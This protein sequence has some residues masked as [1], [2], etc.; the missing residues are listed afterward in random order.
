MMH[1]PLLTPA[2]DSQGRP[3]FQTWPIKDP[4][5]FDGKY[6]YGFRFTVPPRPHDEDFVWGFVYPFARYSDGWAII[7]PNGIV[8]TTDIGTGNYFQEVFYVPLN[9]YVGL[10]K[11][12]PN[13]QKEIYL[14]HLDGKT[15]SDGST[16][17]IYFVSSKLRNP[18]S[19]SLKF[20][21]AT[22]AP[23]D[24]ESRSALETI[25]G[26]VRKNPPSK[27]PAPEDKPDPAGAPPP[28]S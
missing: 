15:I 20:T 19:M 16:Y 8:Y 21:F 18:L 6:Y 25:L 24:T 11:M 7:P 17:L 13:F 1:F 23:S 4:L 28:S 3:A 2:T 22:V 27:N 26:L 10:P 14:Q 5:V 12:L 9:N